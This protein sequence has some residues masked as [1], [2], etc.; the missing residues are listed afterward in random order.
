MVKIPQE[1]GA[2]ASYVGE[3]FG[4]IAG[5]YDRMN[6]LMTAGRDRAWRRRAV[7]AGRPPPDG[8]A[9]D[10]GCGTGDLA[11]ELA[12]YPLSAVVG[13]DLA[14]PMIRQGQRKIAAAGCGE[15]V[16]LGLGDATSLPFPSGAFDCVVTG[17]T[18]R[19]VADLPGALGELARVTKPGGRVVSLEIF[20]WRSGPLA[21]LVQLYFRRVMPLLGALVAGDKEAYTYLPTSVGSFVTPGKL[22]QLMEEAGLREVGFA[23]LALGTVAIHWGVAAEEAPGKS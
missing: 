13:V 19:N 2:K 6:A 16:H 17:F 23:M 12:R 11:L 15:R 5:R 8:V 20:P 7:R 18:L 22:A 3:M 10:V 4:R 9:L 21:P 14:A 1:P